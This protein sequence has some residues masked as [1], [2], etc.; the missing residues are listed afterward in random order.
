[1]ALGWRVFIATGFGALLFGIAVLV[2]DPAQWR[3]A[4]TEIFV[5]VVLLDIV[6]K[7]AGFV[8][9]RFVPRGFARL[10][11]AAAAGRQKALTETG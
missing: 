8:A 5:G 1:M 10:F 4:L 3:L 2:L 7:A 6:E 9:L 11:R